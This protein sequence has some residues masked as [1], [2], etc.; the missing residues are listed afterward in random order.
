MDPGIMVLLAL[1][2]LVFFGDF[3]DRRPSGDRA[4]GFRGGSP[5]PNRAAPPR[6]GGGVPD[7]GES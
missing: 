7:R 3:G 6:C 1:G 4:G 2:F 5:P